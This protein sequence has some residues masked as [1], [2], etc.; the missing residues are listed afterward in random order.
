VG[1]KRSRRRTQ[2]RAA[3]LDWAARFMGF[4]LASF[5]SHL[6]H[7]HVVVQVIISVQR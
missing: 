7:M 4:V 1:S 3:W 5:L 6:V 2:R